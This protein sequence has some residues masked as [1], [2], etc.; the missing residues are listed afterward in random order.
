MR[1]LILFA[2]MLFATPAFGVEADKVAHFSS[3]AGYGLVAGTVL[4]HYAEQME[5][6]ERMV[7]STGLGLIPGTVYEIYNEFSPHNHFSWG[8]LLADAL[9][10]VTGSVAAE[11]INGQFW[12]S[13]SGKQIKLVGKW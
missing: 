11:L 4:Y 8:D 12:I 10:A 13:A 6:V 5:P 9:G 3:G 1:K 2:M 7:A